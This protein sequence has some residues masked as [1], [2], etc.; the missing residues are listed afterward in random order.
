MGVGATMQIFKGASTSLLVFQD[1]PMYLVTILVTPMIDYIDRL[2]GGRQNSQISSNLVLSCF[3]G[4]WFW[5]YAVLYRV[6]V[7]TFFY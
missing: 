5:L 3:V 4:V 2:F 7:V 1:L 6:C